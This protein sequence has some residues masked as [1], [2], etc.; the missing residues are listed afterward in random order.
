MKERTLKDID[1]V[2]YGLVD[3]I[4]SAKRMISE[5]RITR[6]D[7]AEKISGLVVDMG[8]LLLELQRSKSA[9]SREPERLHAI[10]QLTSTWKDLEGMIKEIRNDLESR[11]SAEGGQP[12]DQ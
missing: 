10:T 6:L 11:S 3:F 7:E 1:E 12:R 4:Q 9:L 5:N 8:S 2:C